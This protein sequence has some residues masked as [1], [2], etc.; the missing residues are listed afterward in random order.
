V[1]FL[2]EVEERIETYGSAFADLEKGAKDEPLSALQKQKLREID[3]KARGKGKYA[4][5]RNAEKKRS[6]FKSKSAP[7]RKYGRD[8]NEDLEEPDVAPPKPP[9]KRKLELVKEAEA[10][11]ES[12]VTPSKKAPAFRV[13]DGGKS[14]T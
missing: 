6:S 5:T 11:A 1:Q 3:K 14:D 2:E 4:D 9:A 10:T 7:P 8:I 12:A 13:I